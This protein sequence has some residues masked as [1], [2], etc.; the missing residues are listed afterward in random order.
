MFDF[1]Y[2]YYIPSPLHHPLNITGLVGRGSC[3][4]ESVQRV[5]SSPLDSGFSSVASCFSD[6][7]KFARML[8]SAGVLSA[9]C[10]L[11]QNPT[12]MAVKCLASFQDYLFDRDI[13]TDSEP[14]N[15]RG[16]RLCGKIGHFARDCSIVIRR[17]ER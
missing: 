6:G 16:C 8:G 3:N 5:A 14:P 4:I 17:K 12:S 1:N 13:L 9:Q 11:V 2:A 10:F 15:D 7:N